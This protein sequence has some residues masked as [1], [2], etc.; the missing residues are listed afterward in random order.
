MS[1][2]NRKHAPSFRGRRVMA[3]AAGS[4]AAGDLVALA[5]VQHQSF[6]PKVL[7]FTIIGVP[8]PKQRAR[9]VRTRTGQRITF[10]PPRTVMY[11]RVVALN[12]T[13]ARNRFAGTWPL[14]A[15]YEVTLRIFRARNAGDA[16]NFQKSFGDG[17]NGAL[18]NDD[19]QIVAW[20]VTMDVD[21]E[22]PRIEAT[23]VAVPVVTVVPMRRAKR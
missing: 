19:K 2:T 4:I 9:T 1:Q 21:R 6:V 12:A 13:I 10:T 17:A 23:V 18:W 7:V 3:I 22:N 14:D 11:E 15:Q 5:P 20:H 16:D 8:V